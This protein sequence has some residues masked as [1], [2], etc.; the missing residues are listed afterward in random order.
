MSFVCGIYESSIWYNFSESSKNFGKGT[1]YLKIQLLQALTR[2][3]P[4]YNLIIFSSDNFA[5]DC[6]SHFNLPKTF[7]LI[8][9]T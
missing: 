8:L 1:N 4:P 6:Q 9:G 7:F 3:A 5:T 2:V